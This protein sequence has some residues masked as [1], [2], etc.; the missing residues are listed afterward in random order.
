MLVAGRGTATALGTVPCCPGCLVV[1]VAYVQSV[2]VQMPVLHCHVPAGLMVLGGHN[3]SQVLS[4]QPRWK[5]GSALHTSH[6]YLVRGALSP[7]SEAVVCVG[8]DRTWRKA[9]NSNNTMSPE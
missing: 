7:L 5:Y 8:E 4:A 1:Q 9:G 2:T 3:S 6:F